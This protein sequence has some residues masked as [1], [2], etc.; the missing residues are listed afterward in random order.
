MPKVATSPAS[1]SN[2]RTRWALWALAAGAAVLVVAWV[3]GGEE[4][5]HAIEKVVTVSAE[6]VE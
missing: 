5:L 6:G 4:P 2:P 1:P 3:D